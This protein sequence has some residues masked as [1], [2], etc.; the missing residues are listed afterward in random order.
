MADKYKIIFD[1]T[2]GIFDEHELG[3]TG[4]D[5]GIDEHMRQ[6]CLELLEYL[7]T[8]NVRCAKSATSSGFWFKNEW[9]TK[10]QLFENFL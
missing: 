2:S 10:E 8:N 4:L 6:S 3:I 1:A 5:N 7:A 9:I